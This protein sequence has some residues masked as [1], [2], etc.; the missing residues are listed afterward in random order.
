M[1]ARGTFTTIKLR[2]DPKDATNT[3]T[4]EI[5]V[6]YFRSGTC[7]EYLHFLDKYQSVVSGQD[8]SDGPKKVAFLRTVLRGDALATFNHDLVQAGD[9]TDPSVEAV[10][11]QLTTHVFPHNALR[12]QERYM[13]R[14]VRKPMDMTVR[15]FR[16]RL[17]ELNDYL[18]RFPP[19]FSENQKMTDA[20]IAEIIEFGVPNSWR[21]EMKRLQFETSKAS[22]QQMMEFC[23]NLEALESK[24]LH[25]KTETT[26]QSQQ[27]GGRA[28]RPYV[29]SRTNFRGGQSS[30]SQAG[31]GSKR[32]KSEQV[33]VSYD[34]SKYCTW[35]K[36]YGHDDNSCRARKQDAA[37]QLTRKAFN[38]Q[39]ERQKTQG[40]REFHAAVQQMVTREV[41]QQ[42]RKRKHPPEG[43]V[44]IAKKHNE[45][46]SDEDN[47][48]IR[49]EYP[50]PEDIDPK[51]FAGL[52]L[53]NSSSSS[54][55]DEHQSHH[56][57]S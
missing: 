26:A 9:D 31:R 13:R 27:R 29:P 46:S 16:S 25:S 53:G 22:S 41:S 20:V 35:H 2:S 12:D 52:E 30:Q 5:Q 18:A 3:N 37:Q 44:H 17:I 42:L 40:T 4:Y 48:C 1:Y 21:G 51:L 7:E 36:A 50:L 32:F 24:P 57:V 11:R 47:I 10:L 49:E 39:Q 19:N 56:I 8:L 6:P 14:R 23:E 55:E 38:E 54:D 28:G 15:E 34:P 43:E 45:F 33:G